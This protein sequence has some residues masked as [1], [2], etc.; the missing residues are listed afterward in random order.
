MSEKDLRDT[1]KTL[2]NPNLEIKQYSLRIEKLT[3][4]FPELK[5][6]VLLYF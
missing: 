4:R 3:F 6:R 1:E 2:I 5:D